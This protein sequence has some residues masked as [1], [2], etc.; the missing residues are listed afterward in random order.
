MPEALD[1]IEVENHTHF[2]N[3][4]TGLSL[5]VMS[6]TAVVKKVCKHLFPMDLSPIVLK[7]TGYMTVP[8]IMI[9]TLITGLA[10]REQLVFLEVCSRLSKIPIAQSLG[11][12]SW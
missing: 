4:Q 2:I 9:G 10:S 1:L 6:V 3:P 5:Q 11:K 7:V 12:V 8:P